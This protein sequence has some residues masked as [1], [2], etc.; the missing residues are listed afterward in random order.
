MLSAPF[1]FDSFPFAGQNSPVRYKLCT[2]EL[3]LQ[4]EGQDYV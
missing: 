4:S 2:M 3:G 1:M